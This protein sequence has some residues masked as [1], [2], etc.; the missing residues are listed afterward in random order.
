[1][2]SESIV[3]GEPLTVM[4]PSAMT[5]IFRTGELESSD[6]VGLS[7]ARR[8]QKICFKNHSF[9]QVLF[10][11]RMRVRSTPSVGQSLRLGN[12]FR[13]HPNFAGRPLEDI[14][15]GGDPPDVL[16]LDQLGERIGVELQ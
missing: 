11:L 6:I 5:A 8:C 2:R 16:C 3:A 15:W 1:M 7:L 12:L 9:K 10:R 4:R 13:R 14:R